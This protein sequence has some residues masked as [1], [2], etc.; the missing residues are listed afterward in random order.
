MSKL[1]SEKMIHS[2]FLPWQVINLFCQFTKRPKDKYMLIINF[3]P[4]PWL[5]MINSQIH[6]YVKIRPYL[7]SCQVLLKATEHL[8]LAHDSYID[9]REVYTTFSLKEITHQVRLDNR[10]IKGFISEEAQ[11]QVI[12]AVKCCPVLEKQYKNQIIIQSEA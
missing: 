6:S 5:F 7:L 11:E 8:F 3:H 12:A 10:R 9:C 1:F 4:E 2:N